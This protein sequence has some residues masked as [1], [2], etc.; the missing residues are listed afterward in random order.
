MTEE[1]KQTEE[2]KEEAK[3]TLFQV[4]VDAIGRVAQD[5]ELPLDA[6]L[7]QIELVKRHVI[8][9]VLAN[10]NAQAAEQNADADT[11]EPEVVTPEVV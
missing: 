5:Q 3:P 2:N 9:N 4:L 10:A 6:I 11:Q 1:T 7:G 8:D